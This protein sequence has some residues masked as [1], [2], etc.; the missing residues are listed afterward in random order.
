[1]KK[2]V[3][4]INLGSPDS[5]EVE[6]VRKYLRE[7]LMDPLVL[8]S[9]WLVRKLVVELAI[10]PTRPAASA[11]AYKKIWWEEGSPLIVISKKVKEKLVD[12]GYDPKMGARP[13]RRTI[14]DQI[15]DAITDFYLENPN[16]KDLRAVMTNKGTIQ[17]K[18]QTPK[19]K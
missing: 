4:L 6:D 5:T 15:E 2:G 9:P 3:L 13:L 1:M 17:I 10:L 11:E 7:F 8:D 19:E 18:A 14:Q 12:L 16:E